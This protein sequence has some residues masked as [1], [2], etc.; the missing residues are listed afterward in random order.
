M[1]V[2][3]NVYSDVL[4]T[5]YLSLFLLTP[6]AHFFPLLFSCFFFYLLFVLHFV[7]TPLSH[8]FLNSP[9][10]SCLFYILLFF[11]SPDW[12]PLPP[13]FTIPYSLS[14]LS[15][16]FCCLPAPSSSFSL[17]HFYLQEQAF[18]HYFDTLPSTGEDAWR[19]QSQNPNGFRPSS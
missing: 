19:W 9:V 7:L 15:L 5:A 6:V 12:P 18:K 1:L 11:L 8:L 3:S 13:R 10:P 17:P 14:C 16:F 2:L 4:Y